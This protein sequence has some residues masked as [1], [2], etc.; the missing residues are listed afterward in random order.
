MIEKA[1]KPSTLG[2]IEHEGIFSKYSLN[3][4]YVL[5]FIGEFE[6]AVVEGINDYDIIKTFNVYRTS[7]SSIDDT[8]IGI[9]K[10]VKK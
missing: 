2:L 4:L 10:K 5:N 1:E 7:K 3:R 9:L 8:Y 6:R